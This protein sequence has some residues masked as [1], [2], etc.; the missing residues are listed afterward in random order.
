M[1]TNTNLTVSENDKWAHAQSAEDVVRLKSRKAE[2]EF[3]RDLFNER[4]PVGTDLDAIHSYLNNVEQ[5]IEKNGRVKNEEFPPERE[6]IDPESGKPATYKYY[7]TSLLKQRAASDRRSSIGGSHKS[8]PH[9]LTYPQDMDD[10][11]D[12]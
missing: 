6:V 2:I 8:V 3:M 9:A 11:S 10:P 1:N 7:S 12:R 4:L 5:I